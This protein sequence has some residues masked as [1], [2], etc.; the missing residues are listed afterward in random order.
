ME[1][2]RGRIGSKTWFWSKARGGSQ[3]YNAD[4]VLK[5]NNDSDDDSCEEEVG[6]NNSLLSSQMKKDDTRENIIWARAS[7]AVKKDAVDVDT[8][9]SCLYNNKESQFYHS[10]YLKSEKI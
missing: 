9:L 2:Q 4:R 7:M 8:F 5:I 3:I 1:D 6:K 10:F